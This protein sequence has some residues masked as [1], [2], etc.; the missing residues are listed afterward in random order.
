MPKGRPRTQPV[1]PQSQ[2]GQI[3]RLPRVYVARQRL[4]AELDVAAQRAVTLVV[5]PAGAGKT[6]GVA[7]WLQQLPVMRSQDPLWIHADESWTPT[8][9]QEVLGSSSPDDDP[10]AE[11][12][13]V[14]VDDAHALPAATMRL[15]DNRLNEAPDTL[16]LLLLSRWDLPLTRLV[17]ELLGHFTILRG[18]LLRMDEEGATELVVEHART[19]DPAVVRAVTERAQGWCAVVVLTARAVGAAP[20]P[21]AAA[22][23]LAVGQVPIADRVASEVFATLTSRQR[24]LLLCVSNEEVVTVAT[25]IHL[26][27]DPQAAEVLVELETTGLLISR[28]PT[29]SGSDPMQTRYRIHPLLAE[30]VRRRIAAGGVDVAQA[31]ATVVRAV[32]LDVERGDVAAAFPRLLAIH[33]PEEAAAVLARDGVEMV[34]RQGRG[35]EIA[36]FVRSYP[37]VV[38]ASPD[39]WF[40][41]AFDRWMA[42]DLE[43][44]RHWIDRFLDHRRGA[45]ADSRVPAADRDPYVAIVRLWRSLLGLEPIYAAVGHAKRVAITSRSRAATDETVAV[46]LP[47][48]MT[49]LGATQNWVGELVEAEAS[50]TVAIGLARTRGH[51][52]LAAAAMSFLAFTEYMA[53]R[54]RACVE[55]ATESLGMADPTADP[56]SG[57]TSARAALALLLGGLVDLPWPDEPLDAR[58]VGTSNRVH[59]ADL[60]TRFWM[61]MRDSR[62]SLLSGAVAEA[63]R[64]LMVPWDTPLLQEA[65]LPEHLRVA[66]LLERAYLAA[67]S[68]DRRLLQELRDRLALLGAPGEAR[69]VDGLLFDLSGDRR[70]A[71]EA[72]A[73]AAGDTAWS[74]PAT[75]ALALTCEAQLLD[76]LGEPEASLEKLTE[77]AIATELRRNA[78]PF[79]GWSRQGTPIETLLA[80]LTTVSPRPWVAE[81]AAAAAGRPD[82]V[83]VFAPST[84]SVRERKTAVDPVVRPVLSPREREVL[85]ELA[86]GATYADIAQALFVSENTVKTHVSSLYGKLAVSRRSDALGVARNL[87]LL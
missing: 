32:R 29:G 4:W 52:Y 83:N 53:G 8:R 77:A 64:I 57:F 58:A 66:L 2:S 56:R 11:R 28:L 72:F 69:L 86:R 40:A 63:E 7:G 31:R 24:H 30:V 33:A 18:D 23:R 78:V 26:S 60:C 20:D 37:N 79:L 74:Q 9:I 47:L 46:A 67:L 71:C 39:T 6:L 25:S 13:L 44:A 5:A 80:R 17:P 54:E 42:D 73:D 35:S 3:P 34:L 84:A 49:Q 22:E 15:L 51:S 61:R 14:V 85:A 16:R 65:E 59:G 75:R 19:T 55:V 21:I 62:M 36:G 50:L 41:I 82:I 12:R 68:S 38:H 27:H 48:L 43:A 1:D 81:L 76:I 10:L 87:H 45:V 70:R